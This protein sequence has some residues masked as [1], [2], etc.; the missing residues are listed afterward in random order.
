MTSAGF[1]TAYQQF[2]YKS[3][4]ARYL[5]DEHRREDWPETVTRYVSFLRE[6]VQENYPQF[7]FTDEL[8]NDLYEAI[9]TQAVMPSMRALMTAG[10][11]LRRDH[12]AGYNCAFLPIDASRSFDEEMFILMNGTGVGYSVEQFSVAESPVIAEEFHPTDTTII[13]DDSRIG[14]AKAFKELLGLLY[15]GQI[16]KWDLT[17][18]RPKGARLKTFGGRSSGPEPLN[19]LFKFTVE[20]FRRAAGRRLNTLEAHDLACM[21]AN[22]VVV[23]GVRRSALISLSDLQDERMRDAKS[24]AWWNAFGYRR[25]ANNSAVYNETPDIGVFIREWLSLYDSKSGERGIF[26]RAATK[27]VIDNANEFRL[28]LL[29]S[30]ARLRDIDWDFGT[31]PCSEIILRPQQFCNLTEVVVR[32][33]DTLEI[34]KWKVRMATILGTFQST[35]TNFKYLNKKWQRNCEDERLLGVS[36]TGIMDNPILNGT[37]PSLL[38]ADL[39]S[40]KAEAITTN[41]ELAKDLGINASAAITCVKPSGT[42]SALNNTAS[43][44]HPRHSEYYIRYVRNL[45]NDPV[46][47]FLK[48]AGVPWEPDVMDPNNTVV[49]KYPIKSPDGAILKKNLSA[50]E[51]LEL[52]KTY[53]IHW[54]EHK[55]SVTVTVKE[56][57]WLKVGAWVYDNFEW[58]SGISF[59]PDD[60]NH[61]Y[62][63][64]PFTTVTKEEYETAL[65]QMPTNI[66]WTYLAMFETEDQTTG[67]QELACTA[68]GCEV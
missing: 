47:T 45:V 46:T 59:L 11:T 53:Q 2:I 56:D 22:I 27:R 31:N 37:W 28:K 6:H 9:V 48:D 54:C 61:T 43:G 34:L 50:L 49:F 38:A 41:A 7:K 12:V 29:G 18:L 30:A 52:W 20:M 57:E 36:L 32:A 19:Q 33:E 40:M 1:P 44:I 64:A 23:G 66:D 62:Q 10:P 3:R 51:H 68:G 14:W 58:M 8:Y 15:M 24:G 63:Q 67:T 4:Y 5:Q 60:G 25:L 13:V 65:A 21:I 17:R 42:V 16:P 39:Q 35:L 26:N 55:P